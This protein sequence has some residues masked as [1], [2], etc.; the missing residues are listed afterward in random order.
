MENSTCHLQGSDTQ[1]VQL[2]QLLETKDWNFL[3]RS[4]EKTRP[5]FPVAKDLSA[6]M[7]IR[8]L[9]LAQKFPDKERNKTSKLIVAVEEL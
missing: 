1:I 5:L 3:K 4:D 6:E 9:L 2:Q 7:E 8:E